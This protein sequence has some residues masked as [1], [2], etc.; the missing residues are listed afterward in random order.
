MSILC[1]RT[2]ITRASASYP[3][4]A[5]K[6]S[7]LRSGNRTSAPS[8]VTGKSWREVKADRISLLHRPLHGFWCSTR[9]VLRPIASV[10]ASPPLHP[11]CVGGRGQL[12]NQSSRTRCLSRRLTPQIPVATPQFCSI[13][14]SA[15]VRLESP[16]TVQV[17]PATVC[18]LDSD[19][20]PPPQTTDYL[21]QSHLHNRLVLVTG[22]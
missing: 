14:P 21:W 18:R 10:S 9:R 4:S 13:D 22:F 8:C 2:S 7:A 5:S 19:T 6:V 17:S 15:C 11:R 12:W 20:T 16:Q 1:S 3:L